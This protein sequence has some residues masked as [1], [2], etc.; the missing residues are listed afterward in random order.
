[1]RKGA[2]QSKHHKSPLRLPVPVLMRIPLCPC[3]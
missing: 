3:C 2:A 1:M